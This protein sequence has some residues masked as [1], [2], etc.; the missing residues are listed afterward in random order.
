M[1]MERIEEEILNRQNT[2][3]LVNPALLFATHGSAGANDVELA[4]ILAAYD[5]VMNLL[6]WQGKP[7]ARLT[8]IF[9]AY[10]ASID[11][12]YHDDYKSVLIAEEIEKKRSE[13]K[14]ISILQQ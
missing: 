11:T 3:Q 2:G 7:V 8:A 5:F 9:S 10:Q 14:G 6:G 4:R 1:T 12:R 13:R